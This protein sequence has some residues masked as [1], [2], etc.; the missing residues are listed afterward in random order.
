MA[1]RIDLN[2]E[3]VDDVAIDDVQLFR[4]ERMGDGSFWIRCYGK[5]K[6]YVFWINADPQGDIIVTHEEE[7]P[8]MGDDIPM[9]NHNATIVEQVEKA[10][11]SKSANG[12]ETVD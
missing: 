1:V 8:V 9:T 7:E 2:E 12:N 4:L 3:G 6:D 5:D 11:E 10:R